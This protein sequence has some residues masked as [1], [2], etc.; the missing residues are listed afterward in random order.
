MG[1]SVLA[2]QLSSLQRLAPNL[3]V[4]LGGGETLQKRKK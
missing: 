3:L 2:K 4:G 1:K